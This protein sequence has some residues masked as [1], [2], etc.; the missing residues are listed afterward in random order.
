[1]K[2]FVVK[3]IIFAFVLALPFW[4][5]FA[6]NQ[7]LPDIYT[8]SFM[9]VTS[10][11]LELL[12]EIDGEKV[13]VT[14]GSN[15]IY[16]LSCEEVS[17]AIGKPVFNMGTTA[18][19]GLPFFISELKPHLNSGDTV[20]LSLEYS[21]LRGEIDYNTVLMALESHDNVWQGFPLSY[22]PDVARSYLQYIDD[23]RVDLSTLYTD[24]NSGEYVNIEQKDEA[25][26]NANF[27]DFGDN[28]TLREGNILEN[29]YNTQDIWHLDESIV[30]SDVLKELNSFKKWADRNGVAVYMTY[31]TFNRLALGGTQSD[32]TGMDGALELEQYL[33]ENCDI[34]WLGTFTEGIMHEDYF[35]DTNNHLNSEGKKLRTEDFINDYISVVLSN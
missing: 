17:N 24:A 21:V 35:S 13:V 31:A 6:Y 3:L 28:T 20:V 12:S 18:Y 32:E 8:A 30:S 10:K 22:A 11:K 14:G 27:N 9:G 23:K 2:K 29:L 7:R 34:P 19:L 4:A 1:M 15:L 26:Y 16:G 25:Y 5:Y 33:T